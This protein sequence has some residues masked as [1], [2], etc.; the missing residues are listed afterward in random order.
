MTD[1]HTLL[2]SNEFR[3]IIDCLQEGTHS[4]SIIRTYPVL[5]ALLKERTSFLPELSQLRRRIWHIQHDTDDPPKCSACDNLVEWKNPTSTYNTFCSKKCAQ[6]VRKGIPRS[7]QVVDKIKQTK[8]LNP[9][10]AWNKG[11]ARTDEQNLQLSA[12]RKQRFASGEITHWNKG[13][14]TPDHVRRKTSITALSQHRTYLETSKQKR[15]ETYNGKK[16]Q[17]W[18]HPSTL[19]T[20][21][22]KSVQTNRQRYNRNSYSQQ[23]IPLHVLDKLN[24]KSWMYSEHVIQQKSLSRISRELGF[25]TQ[26][27]TT[28]MRYL[29]KHD[30]PT[31]HF[32][33]SDNETQLQVF[34][35]ECD[36]HAV[37][38]TR[39]IIS[40]KE[41][42]IYVPS[43]ALGIEYC[44]LFWHNSRIVGK[45]YH[46]NK[47]KQCN[48][49][50]IRLLTIFEDEWLYKPGIVKDKILNILHK[51]KQSTV[52][53]RKT[54]IV[55]PSSNQKTSFFEQYHIQGN[56]PG[57][58]SYGLGFNNQLVACITFIDMH[59]GKF[60][61]NRYATSCNVPGGF[62]RLLTHFQNNNQWSEIVSFADLRWSEGD[63]YERC[64]FVLDY[65][66][67][68]DYYYIV[69]CKRVHK[70]NYRHK[71]LPR[72][73]ESYDPNLSEIQNTEACG[74]HRIYDCGKNRYVLINKHI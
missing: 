67:P 13:N 22:A 68:P 10:P 2:S 49:Q 15:T 57:S 20:S 58:I 45:H 32:S 56:G 28:V 23:H 64:G 1:I 59:S 26:D 31:Q 51:N 27:M 29:H 14:V 18:V 70:F 43:H 47:L 19:G 38:N 17:G 63:V 12:I 74:V 3:V 5:I 62:S 52:F 54:Q 37:Y 53:A 69:G 48:Q 6:S 73:L 36:V 40:P 24:D 33:I 71:N 65:V 35:Q 55:Q 7:E 41:L 60:Y 34:I 16:Q 46:E 11:I 21:L 72:L 66:L 8:E 25:K 4:N 9:T 30:I 39:R 42:D 50:N 61:L 44:G